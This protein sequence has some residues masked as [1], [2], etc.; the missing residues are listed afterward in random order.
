MGAGKIL[1][2]SNSAYAVHRPRGDRLASLQ[3]CQ[4]AGLPVRALLT[5]LSVLLFC[6]S[7]AFQTV[8]FLC[9]SATS[10]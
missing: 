7:R 10:R 2:D 3:V 1:I 8:L 5:K 9:V 4:S 6:W